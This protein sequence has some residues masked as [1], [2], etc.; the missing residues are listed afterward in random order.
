MNDVV[1]DFCSRISQAAAAGT[2][3]AIRGGN[4]KSFY[5]GSIRGETLD[6]RPYAGIIDYEPKELVLTVR[7]GTPIADP[8]RGR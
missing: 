3:L 8:G 6:V 5:G 4:S 1:K 7:A 2:P